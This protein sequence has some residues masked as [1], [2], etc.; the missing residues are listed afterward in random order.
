[1]GETVGAGS[2]PRQLGR[3]ELI[4]RIGNGGM[5]DVYLARQRGPMGF[6]KLVVLKLAHP[7]L[8]AQKSFIEMLLREAR[9]A[10]LLKHANVVDVYELGEVDG[11]YYI[12][13]E[14][15]EGEPMLALL[16]AER[17]HDPLDALSIARII[18]DAAEGLHAAHELRS[19]SGERIG[20]VHHDVSPGNIMVLYSGQVKLVDFGVANALNE[21]LLDANGRKMVA[22]KLGY[23]AP[24]KLRGEAF[25][26]RSDLFSLGVVLWE[27][28]TC[29]RLYKGDTDAAVRQQVLTVAAPA[30]SSVNSGVPAALDVIC[31][32]ALA[33]DPSQRYAS[34][35]EMAA[36]LETMLR[37]ARYNN[38]NALIA[39]YMRHTFASRL[40]VREQLIR[41]ASSVA[42]PTPSTVAAALDLNRQATLTE[43]P[44]AGVPV[45]RP[46][47][48]TLLGGNMAAVA[49]SPA[50]TGI[51]SIRKGF[52]AVE[53]PA[54]AGVL[55]KVPAPSAPMA[56]V[57]AAPVPAFVA[58]D[59]TAS[60]AVER[61]VP[62]APMVPIGAAVTMPRAALPAPTRQPSGLTPAP[63]ANG[64]GAQ[65]S[66]AAAFRDPPPIDAAV[67]MLP[68]P[69][70]LPQAAEPRMANQDAEFF[71]PPKPRI[72]SEE[73][74]LD[75][76]WQVPPRSRLPWIIGAVAVAFAA[77]LM[78]VVLGGKRGTQRVQAAAPR[79]A[80]ALPDAAS[81][82]V[83]VVDAAPATADAA[84]T[85]VKGFV[86]A[87]ARTADA[88]T[89]DAR[90][91][92][93]KASVAQDPMVKKPI[94]PTAKEPS[95]PSRPTRAELDSQYKVALQ[96]FLKGDGQAITGFRGIVRADASYAT[97]WRGLGLALA[98]SGSKAEAAKALKK[99]LA[100]APKAADAAQIRTRVEQLK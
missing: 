61:P 80:V 1:M 81:A 51:P 6:E 97:A 26:H 71:D 72:A 63:F 10:A 93:V 36:A 85:V 62:M 67:P 12:A 9:V 18:A 100:L 14:Y 53:M 23:L 60:D 13:M 88:R 86:V 74:D 42:G 83:L 31:L 75:E 69:P 15:L 35:A 49:A 64:I 55:A 84:A 87:D 2:L 8:A 19:L 48:S 27:S 17:D 91:A 11:T 76:P 98:K 70:V 4:T 28:L 16:R 44:A 37:H 32:K 45:V 90:T 33:K 68:L 40:S 38:K 65:A 22:G 56:S 21:A 39:K 3:Y 5:A 52:A 58:T 7:S 24:E 94:A 99:Y 54:L 89:A 79:V 47:G 43:T 82:D 59:T 95:K 50:A 25:D 30:P 34:A 77:M 96:Q 41:E 46:S 73:D 92:L 78:I 57:P 20:L 66:N 29:R